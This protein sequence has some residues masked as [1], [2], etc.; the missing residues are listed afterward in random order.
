MYLDI[1]S[2]LTWRL[3][4]GVA[5]LCHIAHQHQVWRWANRKIAPVHIAF[6]SSCIFKHFEALHVL[7]MRTK[8]IECTMVSSRVLQT[9]GLYN[10]LM[11]SCKLV[12]SLACSPNCWRLRLLIRS[13]FDWLDSAPRLAMPTLLLS[14]MLPYT[15]NPCNHRNTGEFRPQHQF[16]YIPVHL[17]VAG[18]RALWSR[19]AFI[20]YRG[21]VTLFYPFCK[22]IYLLCLVGI[23]PIP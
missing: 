11:K 18:V 8:I 5:V 6:E 14:N 22:G 15:P 12:S 16:L 19:N 9:L 3:S 4:H 7:N 10:S 17:S 21:A 1:M 2:G 20:V 13:P 23:P